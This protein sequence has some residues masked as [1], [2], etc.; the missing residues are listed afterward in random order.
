MNTYISSNA[1]RLYAA[2]ENSYGAASFVTAANR[3]P[4]KGLRAHQTV[5]TSRRR[6]K[7][8]RVRI[9]ELRIREGGAQ[10]SRRK[11]T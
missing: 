2:I 10:R 9:L 8:E 11:V 3:F 4:T 5:Q 7:Q 6:T 1:N